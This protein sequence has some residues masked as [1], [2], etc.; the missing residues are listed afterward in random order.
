M[1]SFIHVHPWLT[2]CF[3]SLPGIYMVEKLGRRKFLFYGA[4]FMGLCQLTVGI[5]AV[6]APAAQ[7]SKTVLVVFTLLFIAGFASTWGPGAWVLIAELFPLKVSSC[8]YRFAVD[9]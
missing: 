9:S 8:S 4:I 3:A 1:L 6:A 2:T 7:A 5:S